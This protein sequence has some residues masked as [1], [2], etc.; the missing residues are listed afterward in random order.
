MSS[1][2][3]NRIS[4]LPV[5]LEPSAI[6]IIKADD[7][8]YV[9]LYFTNNDA[10]EI[11]Q[12]LGIRDI[13][14]LIMNAL[15]VWVPKRSLTADQWVSPITIDI[16]GGV[17]GQAVFNGSQN[18]I[19]NTKMNADAGSADP[20]IIDY[21]GF[22]SE[23]ESGERNWLLVPL[24]NPFPEWPQDPS[25]YTLHTD[26]LIRAKGTIMLSVSDKYRYGYDGPY[27]SWSGWD[28]DF[29]IT[30]NHFGVANIVGS[31]IN[32]LGDPGS[33]I[34]EAYILSIKK[35]NAYMP[36]PAEAAD[37]FTSKPAAVWIEVICDDWRGVWDNLPHVIGRLDVIKSN[38][39]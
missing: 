39:T 9:D 21:D 35:V 16:V 7:P 8:L 12:I 23:P 24:V 19:V 4:A 5:L 33:D 6:Y 20:S 37:G 31:N 28:I 25:H 38:I 3:I 15:E 13:P 18:I 27:D 29:T 1:I 26:E 22:I 10:T 36:T 2:A 11:R 17:L 30:V 32:K 34:N 14:K